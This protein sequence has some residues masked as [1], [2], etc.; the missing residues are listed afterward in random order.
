[1]P[2]TWTYYGGNGGGLSLDNGLNGG[3]GGAT[4]IGGNAFDVIA[5]GSMGGPGITPTLPGYTGTLPLLAGGGGAGGT[6]TNVQNDDP[7]CVAHNYFGGGCFNSVIT[8]ERLTPAPGGGGQGGIGVDANG[9]R[10]DTQGTCG[11]A[12]GAGGGGGGGF[13]LIGGDGAGGIIYAWFS[14]S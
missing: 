1:L 3:G 4:R 9:S 10:R 11:S 5:P 13:N 14:N 12:P 7:V 6:F 8:S 2:S